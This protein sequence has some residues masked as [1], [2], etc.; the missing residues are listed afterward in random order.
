M[1]NDFFQRTEE[2][3]SAPE[4]L[5]ATVTAMVHD[6]MELGA[7]PLSVRI[8][9]GPGENPKGEA[10]TVSVFGEFTQASRYRRTQEPA[11][12]SAWKT[13]EPDEPDYG[14]GVPGQVATGRRVKGRPE[15]VA[16]DSVE[17]RAALEKAGFDPEK[18]LAADTAPPPL[19]GL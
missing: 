8:A 6:A 14:P 2:T 7:L 3:D 5:S 9:F 4:K 17:G 16:A 18:V 12:M 15:L 19:G 11:R 10:M 13:Y 1:G